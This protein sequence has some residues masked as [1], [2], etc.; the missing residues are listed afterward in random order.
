MDWKE[1]IGKRIFVKLIN[2]GVYS[3]IVL[4]VDDSF[5]SIRDKFNDYSITCEMQREFRKN[6]RFLQEC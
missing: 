5:F 2:G 3:G 1:W 6:R 4:D